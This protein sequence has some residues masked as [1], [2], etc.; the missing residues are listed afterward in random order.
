MSDLKKD[1]LLTPSNVSAS[2]P[3][4]E[5]SFSAVQIVFPRHFN[6]VELPPVI[7]NVSAPD[8]FHALIFV[9]DAL[10][11]VVPKG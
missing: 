3:E 9:I 11:L 2:S 7:E 8:P 5:P 6:P 1:P 10:P 4:P